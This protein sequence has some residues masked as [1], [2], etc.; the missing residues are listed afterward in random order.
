MLPDKYRVIITSPWVSRTAE[1]ADGENDFE[2]FELYAWDGQFFWVVKTEA[3]SSRVWRDIIAV[4]DMNYHGSAH[5]RKPLHVVHVANGML[6]FAGGPSVEN[7]IDV[8]DWRYR[9][10]GERS[11]IANLCALPAE[12]LAAW[13]VRYMGHSDAIS[14]ERA[15][16]PALFRYFYWDELAYGVNKSAWSYA[17]CQP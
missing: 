10:Y 4:D 15:I 9:Y 13:H 11:F 17:S 3:L 1:E 14:W 16:L 5:D 6:T 12:Q 8:D 7:Y 2:H